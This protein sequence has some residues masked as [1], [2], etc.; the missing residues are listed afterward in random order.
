M[1]KVVLNVSGKKFVTFWK[2]LKKFPNTRLG[3]L[4]KT[5][6][7]YDSSCDE[8]FFDRN[9]K[10]MTVILDM[11]RGG[12]LH[13]PSNVCSACVR[14]ELTFWDIPEDLISECCWKRYANGKED[15]AIVDIIENFMGVVPEFTD[16]E[17]D[18]WRKRI[19]NTLEYP[20]YSRVAMVWNATK[21]TMVVVITVAVMLGTI[22]S[23]RLGLPQLTKGNRTIKKLDLILGTETA[24]WINYTEVVCLAFFSMDMIAR[25]LTS[26]S[27]KAFVRDWL[28]I[29]DLVLDLIMWLAFVLEFGGNLL[30]HTEVLRLTDHV[31]K[32]LFVL[33]VLRLF[34]FVRQYAMMKILLLT[35]RA[36]FGQLLLL[37]VG[38]T[39]AVVIFATVIYFVEIAMGVDTFDNIPIA[40][41]WAVVT[42]T[43]VGYGDY[44]PHSAPGYIVG[45]LCSLSGILLLAMPV[46][47]IA[48]NFTAYHVNLAA[49]DQRIRRLKLLNKKAE[50][51]KGFLASDCTELEDFDESDFKI[52]GQTKHNGISHNQVQPISEKHTKL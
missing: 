4:S 47:I 52:N 9:P 17:H 18:N 23:L 43:T 29:V 38:L 27:R 40:I 26:P 42:M 20:T 13:F 22:P 34:H 25:F 51:N 24:L 50:T 21:M 30:G 2:T 19:S 10:V 12:E 35:F 1:D 15:K 41:W 7:N 8:F 45:V 6:A 14:Q 33:N 32:A 44:H 36:S 5:S 46:A 31:L 37:C 49:R 28:N 39:I 16:K 3:R 48:S 11:Y